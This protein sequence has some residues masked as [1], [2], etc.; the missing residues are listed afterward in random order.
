MVVADSLQSRLV[1]PEWEE[2]SDALSEIF[3]RCE[4][5]TAGA[6]AS[7]IPQLARYSPHHWVAVSIIHRRDKL[8]LDP[9]RAD[10]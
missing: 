4:G 9:R 5:N 7:Y 2:F 3:E 10:G 6:V 1:I 8:L